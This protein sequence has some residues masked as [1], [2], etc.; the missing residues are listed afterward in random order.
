MN[1]L[2]AWCTNDEKGQFFGVSPSD[3]LVGHDVVEVHTYEH[4]RSMLLL[5][6]VEDPRFDVVLADMALPPPPPD[7]QGPSNPEVLWLQQAGL[8]DENSTVWTSTLLLLPAFRQSFVRGFGIFL[9]ADFELEWEGEA[10]TFH[11]L[12]LSRECWLPN[13]ARDWEGL[14][15]AVVSRFL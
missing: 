12:H 6:C 10:D 11:T 1:I 13:G 9:P 14:L 3:V 7:E 5:S 8:A 2:C 15:N 4:A